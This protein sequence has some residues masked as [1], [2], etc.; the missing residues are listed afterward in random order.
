MTPSQVLA[1]AR[2]AVGRGTIYYLGA[3]GM[4]PEAK[5]PGNILGQLDCS[6]FVAYCL[7]VS[8]KTDDPWYAEQNGG[9]L[10]TTAIFRDCATPYGAFDGIEWKEARPSD[11]LVWGDRKDAEG[12]THQG[13]VGIVSEVDETGPVKVIHCSSSN[14]KANQDAIA[15]TAVLIFTQHGAR[16]ARSK[17]VTED[18]A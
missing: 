15:E 12:K 11:L 18:N 5:Q 17:W 16:V 9:W 13:H 14:E 8:R 4:K 3:G 2:S 6:G 10:E 1:R 7:G